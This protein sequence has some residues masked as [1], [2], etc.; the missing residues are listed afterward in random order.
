VS[1]NTSQENDEDIRSENQRDLLENPK[2][3]EVKGFRE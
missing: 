3:D 1:F 2:D